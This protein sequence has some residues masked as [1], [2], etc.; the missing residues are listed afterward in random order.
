MFGDRLEHLQLGWFESHLQP[1]LG[2]DI[3]GTDFDPERGYQLIATPK[4]KL[5]L[6]R[7][8]GL[9][10]A[11]EA[12]AELLDLDHPVDIPRKNV[13]A[14]K[15]YGGLYDAFVAALRPPAAVIDR[16]Y[17]SRLVQHFYSAEEIARFREFWS[18]R[19]VERSDGAR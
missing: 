11:S 18:V 1:T 13:G 9:G 12:L 4:V 19:P 6:L 7:C 15:D 3:Y 14:E 2:I 10:V 5:L 17:S 16:A 8:E